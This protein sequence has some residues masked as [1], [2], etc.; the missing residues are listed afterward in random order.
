MQSF[1][2]AFMGH[3]E[4]SSAQDVQQWIRRNRGRVFMVYQIGE[5][6]SIAYI[7][8]AVLCLT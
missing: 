5:I 7:K 2:I 3:F 1:N 4:T 6:L 8:A